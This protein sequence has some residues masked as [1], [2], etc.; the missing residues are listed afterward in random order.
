MEY[1]IV[2]SDIDGTLLN[3]QRELSET[4]ILE[5][6][7][8]KDKVPFILISARMPAAMKHLQKE[9]E[10]ESL[11]IISYNGGLVIVDDTVVSSTEISLEIIEDLN[12]MNAQLNCHLS[13]YHKDEW[14]VPEMDQW[15]LREE[16]NTKVTPQV[17]LNSEVIEKWRSENK[18]AHK[19]M[20][21]GDE[22]HIDQI[23]DFLTQK[24][25][26]ELH[27][28]RSK[29]T[30]LEIANKKISKFTAIE[31]LL[32]QH[33]GFP[34]QEAIAIG[35]NY[36][37]VEMLRNIGYGIAV[38]NARPEA[39]EASN[40]IAENSIEDGVAKSLMKIFGF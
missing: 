36:N 25:P 33:Y 18:G 15:A 1:K 19:I 21:M 32:K 29:N 38:G 7:K 10:I 22:A 37:D 30:Y 23:K 27:L 16:N 3:E 24:Y 12:A 17:K 31:F 4:T 26:D 2:F 20:A 40:F 14:Y 5:I 39:L 6:K 34:T 13:L 9:L 11:P 28:Y 8:L 35:D